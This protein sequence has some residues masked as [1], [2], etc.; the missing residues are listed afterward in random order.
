MSQEELVA[1]CVLG[2]LAGL[3]ALIAAT[4]HA[5][6]MAAALAFE[7]SGDYAL[8]TPLLAGTTIAALVSRRLR[9]DSIYTEE[10]RRRGIPWRG[11]LTERLAHAVIARD[12]LT[13]DPP[14]VAAEAK[15]T[16]ALEELAAPNV[17]V[18]YVPGPPLRAIDLNHAKRLW[19][20]PDRDQL[21]VGEIAHAVAGVAPQDSLLDLG[22]SASTPG[23][24]RTTSSRCPPTGTSRRS[25]CRAR[26]VE[27]RCAPHISRKN[28]G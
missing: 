13:L 14:I 10:L 12:I 23:R 19:A 9:P 16:D 4:T 8:D 22:R 2:L 3:A 5:P 20:A 26:S 21:R 15:V 25:P 1:H 18:V 11:S 24:R 7:L 6:L 28:S 17:R 27:F